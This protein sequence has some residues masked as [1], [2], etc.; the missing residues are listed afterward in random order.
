MFSSYYAL[1]SGNLG[2]IMVHR[3]SACFTSVNT[4]VTS[5]SLRLYDETF[6]FISGLCN[7]Y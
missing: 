7:Q 2:V 6:N 3:I 1:V 5:K 4:F